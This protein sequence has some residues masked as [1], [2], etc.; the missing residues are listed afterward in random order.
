MRLAEEAIADVVASVV[1][2]A[3]DDPVYILDEVWQRLGKK[4]TY[5]M[6]FTDASIDFI[7]FVHLCIRWLIDAKSLA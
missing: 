5:R 1:V 7:P 3:G 6:L 2:G 4:P